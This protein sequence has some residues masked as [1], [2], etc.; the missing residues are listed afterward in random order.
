MVRCF[1]NL[2][3]RILW[4]LHLHMEIDYVIKNTKLE[5]ESSGNLK[6][7]PQGTI[8]C[9]ALLCIWMSLLFPSLSSANCLECLIFVCHLEFWMNWSSLFPP[10]AQW[11]ASVHT[12]SRQQ[13]EAVCRVRTAWRK[14]GCKIFLLLSNYREIKSKFPETRFPW[15]V[16]CCYCTTAQRVLE[17]ET[18]SWG[19]T[20]HATL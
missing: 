18:T 13:I 8:P 19:S 14:V 17:H 15:W 9:M 10:C 2:L 20:C 11:K 1:K 7:F 6:K 16:A 3:R 4:S 12:Q 5:S